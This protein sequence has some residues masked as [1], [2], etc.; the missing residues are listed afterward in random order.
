MGLEGTV[1]ENLAAKLR[2]EQRPEK[3]YGSK[4]G[5]EVWGTSVPSCRDGRAK[6]RG[7]E[8]AR[9]VWGADFTCLSVLVCTALSL[10][11]GPLNG[12]TV[13]PFRSLPDPPDPPD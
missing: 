5:R 2:F 10:A 8:P 4:T 12:A 9:P 7:Q 11:L 13:P 6:D 3:H 1:R